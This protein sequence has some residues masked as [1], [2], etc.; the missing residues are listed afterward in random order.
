MVQS[1]LPWIW[2]PGQRVPGGLWQDPTSHCGTWRLG[3]ANAFFFTKFGL[4]ALDPKHENLHNAQQSN[5]APEPS[6][7]HAKS[8]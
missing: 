3:E 2:K 5:R 4:K 6:L 1:V 8:T 7:N